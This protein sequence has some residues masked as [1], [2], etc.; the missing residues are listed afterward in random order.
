MVRKGKET[1]PVPDLV[2]TYRL[3]NQRPAEQF[4]RTTIETETAL[5]CQVGLEQSTNSL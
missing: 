3:F 2:N 1:A 4:V 5:L